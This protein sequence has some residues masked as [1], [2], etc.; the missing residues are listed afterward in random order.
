MLLNKKI[1]I[2]SQK[3]SLPEPLFDPIM[4]FVCLLSSRFLPEGAYTYLLFVTDTTDCVCVKKNYPVSIF[5]DLTQTNKRY[6]HI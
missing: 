1:I 3:Q 5:S 6:E 4:N 2:K